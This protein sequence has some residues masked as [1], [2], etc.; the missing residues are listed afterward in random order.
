M[1]SKRFLLVTWDGAGNLPPEL[2]LAR[3]L[4][5]HG[6]EVHL[7]AQDGIKERA[8]AAGCKFIPLQSAAQWDIAAEKQPE[9]EL[10]YFIEHCWFSQAYSDDITSMVAAST[11][12]VLLIDSSLIL[13]LATALALGIPTVVLHH[14]QYGI[15]ESGPLADLWEA[16]F[17]QAKDKFKSADVEPFSRL[18]SLLV[19]LG[20]SWTTSRLG[21]SPA[22]GG[23]LAGLLLA[24]TEH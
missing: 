10:A 5:Y 13:G 17:A 14:T 2:A 23:F 20:M 21:L 7:S 12:D 6:H 15:M 11:Y 8:E 19:L 9:D 4:I 24:E 1:G 3:E 18:T 16:Q 22:V